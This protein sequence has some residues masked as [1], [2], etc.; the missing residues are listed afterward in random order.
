MSNI[1]TRL[2]E[3]FDRVAES[4][5]VNR[6]I[7]EIVTAPRRRTMPKLVAGVAAFAAV[8]AFFVAPMLMSG[9]PD[10]DVA[11]QIATVGNPGLETVRGSTPSA[12]EGELPRLLVDASLLGDLNLVSVVEYETSSEESEN[13]LVAYATAEDAGLGSRIWIV[14]HAEGTDFLRGEGYRDGDWE[15]ASVDSGR[16]YVLRNPEA[17]LVI[18]D[19]A[20]GDEGPAVLAYGLNVEA[21]DLIQ[22]VDGLVDN[23]DGWEAT[24]L[25][26]SFSP[27]YSGPERVDGKRISLGWLNQDNTGEIFLELVYEGPLTLERTMYQV[28]NPALPADISTTQVRGKTA[29]RIS[30]LPDDPA[31]QAEGSQ[32]V[33]Q[34]METPDVMARLI[35]QGSAVDPAQVLAALQIVD[36]TTWQATLDSAAT[37]IDPE[38]T[39]TTLAPAT[40]IVGQNED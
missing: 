4:T 13:H 15:E 6:R 34:W 3:T 32:T 7:D 9:T 23:G 11:G 30:S 2:R 16:A 26:E 18:W 28:L 24:Y 8:I 19:T 1:D 27:I 10:G 29:L 35:V 37:M 31:N 36:A 39:P 22:V 12:I 25:P 5:K 14:T 17:P 21:G 40:T 33:F 20:S 38:A